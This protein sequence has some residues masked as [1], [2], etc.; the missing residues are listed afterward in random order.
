MSCA[1]VGVFESRNRDKVC[2]ESRHVVE[3]CKVPIFFV[4][5]Q[6]YVVCEQKEVE[7]NL[8]KDWKET[9]V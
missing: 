3:L 4:V 7:V 6:L 1:T 5:S 8:L 9:K 2:L